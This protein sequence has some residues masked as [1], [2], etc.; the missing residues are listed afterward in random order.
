MLAALRAR[1]AAAR[2]PG[3]V[4]LVV[5]GTAGIGRA[6]AE[7]LA[8]ADYAVI[9]VGRDAKRGEEAVASCAQRGS[10]LGGHEFMPCDASHVA[11]VRACAAAVAAKHP[12]LDA[13]VLSPGIAT[14]SGRNETSEG[15]DTKLAVHYFGRVAFATDLLPALAA[16]PSPRVL[17]VLSAG[18]HGACCLRWCMR[19][20]SD[21]RNLQFQ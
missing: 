7:R 9:I 11:A 2:F 4:A 16:A 10:Q 21:F 15:L 1:N 12:R 17:S 20:P 18:V 6:V 13:L 19:F 5:G 14:I 3:R 8:E